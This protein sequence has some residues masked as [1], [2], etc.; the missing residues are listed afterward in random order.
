VIGPLKGFLTLYSAQ[1]SNKAVERANSSMSTPPESSP[2][3]SEDADHRTPIF[4][5]WW[6]VTAGMTL[7]IYTSGVFFYGFT[8]LF[9]PLRAEF[10]WTRAATSLAFTLQRGES[11]VAAPIV[12][13]LADHYG[14]RR[15]MIGGVIIAGLGLVL[16]SRINSLPTFYAAFFISAIGFS[17]A[18]PTVGYIAIANWFRRRRSR[19]MAILATGAGISGFMVGAVVWLIDVMGWRQALLMLGV[20][21]WIIGIPLSMTFRHRP[22]QYGT[23]PDGIPPEALPEGVQRT[24]DPAFSFSRT[25]RT[26]AFWVLGIVNSLWIFAHTGVVAHIIPALTLDAH[27]S[28]AVAGIA[29]SA[30]PVFSIGGRLVMG[31]LADYYDKRFIMITSMGSQLIGLIVLAMGFDSAWGIM[32][33]MAFYGFGIGGYIPVRRALQ[34]DLFGSRDFGKVM[35]AMETV[36][37]VG[38]LAGPVFAGWVADVRDSY[39]LAFWVFSLGIIAAMP[40]MLRAKTRQPQNPETITSA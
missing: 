13:I 38:G 27:A 8:A 4:Y 37:L 9:N 2:P 30:I 1:C 21:L 34:A 40:L 19:A 39:Q 33:S 20:G 28:L 25:V 12:G 29:A 6:I 22:E 16:L 26:E 36:A 15:V 24:P 7:S 10:G 35:G 31:T 23:Y 14:P 5:G 3:G 32:I 17:A 18:S 11:G